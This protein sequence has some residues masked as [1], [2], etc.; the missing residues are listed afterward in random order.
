M[1]DVILI[2]YLSITVCFMYSA[3]EII[4]Y[5]YYFI[6]FYNTRVMGALHEYAGSPIIINLSVRPSV[7]PI[8]LVR[9]QFRCDTT[10]KTVFTVQLSSF[11]QTYFRRRRSLLILRLYHYVCLSVCQ[12]LCLQQLI[13]WTLSKGNNANRFLRAVYICL[14]YIHVCWRF[15]MFFYEN[16]TCY[17]H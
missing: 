8:K 10:T 3:L 4:Y 15:N 16:V 11:V 14:K 1:C 9:K 2:F 17:M 5:V 6:M 7:Y 12:H 13:C